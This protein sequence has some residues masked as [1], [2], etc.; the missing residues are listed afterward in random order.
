[1]STILTNLHNAKT[2]EIRGRRIDVGQPCYLVAEIGINHNG[3]IDLAKRTILA[4]KSAG[5]G[6]RQVPKLSDRRF[7]HR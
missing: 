7:H 6:R 3:D 1:M 5:A 4:A 2:I